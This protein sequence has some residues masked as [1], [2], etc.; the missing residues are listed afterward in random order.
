MAKDAW[1]ARSIESRK[2]ISALARL[3][4]EVWLKERYVDPATLPNK[5]RMELD[6]ADFY[7]RHFGLFDND[8]LLVGGGRLIHEETI[9]GSELINLLNDIKREA[10]DPILSTRLAPRFFGLPSDLYGAFPKFINE[11]KEMLE[12]NVKFAEISRIVVME[13]LR[14]H[15]LSDI[16]IS[17]MIDYAKRT[18]INVLLLTCSTGME[19]FYGRFGFERYQGVPTDVYGDIKIQS[20]VMSLNFPT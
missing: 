1:H 17:K 15:G 11:Y 19:T 10:D 18:G 9:G 3:R 8:G 13:E 20:I 6:I 12:R 5:C 4:Y 2:D 14:G 7:S 16:L